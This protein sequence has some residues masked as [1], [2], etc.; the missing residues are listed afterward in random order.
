[1]ILLRFLKIFQ[2][3][4][5][6][7]LEHNFKCLQNET[8]EHYKECEQLKLELALMTKTYE[9][10]H[11]EY[12]SLIKEYNSLKDQQQASTEDLQEFKVLRREL[13]RLLHT[14]LEFSETTNQLTGKCENQRKDMITTLR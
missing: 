12:S 6:N 10:T 7:E 9:H 11:I 1:M 13:D 4:Q 14:T 2:A 5:V 8:V 3:S